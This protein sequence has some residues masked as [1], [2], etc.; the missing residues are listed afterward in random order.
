MERN[1]PEFDPVPL[2]LLLV[3]ALLFVLLWKI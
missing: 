1:E 2:L 3:F